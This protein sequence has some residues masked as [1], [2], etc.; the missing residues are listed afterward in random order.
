MLTIV[1][2]VAGGEVVPPSELPQTNA[3]DAL[4]MGTVPPSQNSLGVALFPLLSGGKIMLFRFVSGAPVEISSTTAL[5]AVIPCLV[6][7]S[8][9]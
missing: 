9:L 6:H 7:V 8:Q 4:I 1:N 2:Y 5:N 3:V